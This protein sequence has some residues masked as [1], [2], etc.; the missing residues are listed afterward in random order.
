M[1]VLIRETSPHAQAASPFHDR[2]LDAKEIS[3]GSAPDCALQILGAGVARH[4]GTL[5]PSNGGLRLSC[6]RGNTVIVD[7]QPVS[8]ATLATGAALELAG[9]TLT[10]LEPPAGFAAALAITRGGD[11]AAG[12]FE[13]AYRTSLEQT[14]LSR[15]KPAWLLALLVLA[16]GLLL[17]WLLPRDSVPRWAS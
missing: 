8:R 3:F 16:L 4:H 5:T 10:V 13:A 6:A 2:E 11:V 17:P 9:T 14:W 12:D 7:G 15:R 1:L